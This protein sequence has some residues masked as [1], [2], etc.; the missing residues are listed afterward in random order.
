[1]R[2]SAVKSG[3][4]VM[5]DSNPRRSHRPNSSEIS[6]L[7]FGILLSVCKYG[8]YKLE[9]STTDGTT[10]FGQYCSCSIGRIKTPNTYLSIA[11]VD[12]QISIE[13]V[14]CKFEA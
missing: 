8:L 13:R 2:G 6:V 4:P 9:R 1:M 12:K 10:D 14:K 11:R 7:F 5:L 3:R